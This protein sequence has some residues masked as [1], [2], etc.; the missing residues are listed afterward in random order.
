MLI[1]SGTCHCQPRLH[2]AACRLSVVAQHSAMF[3]QNHSEAKP[4]QKFASP[5]GGVCCVRM[6]CVVVSTKARLAAGC[7]VH[8]SEGAQRSQLFRRRPVRGAQNQHSRDAQGSI[9]NDPK[10]GMHLHL[11]PHLP[12]HSLLRCSRSQR[13]GNAASKTNWANAHQSA[14]SYMFTPPPVVSSYL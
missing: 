5:S 14:D 12:L 7:D 8:P 10:T 1:S 6:S 13:P 4:A 9:R 2:Q 11:L 3:S